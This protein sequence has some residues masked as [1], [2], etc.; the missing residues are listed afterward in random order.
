[1]GFFRGAGVYFQHFP[2]FVLRAQFLGVLVL[3]RGVFVEAEVAGRGVITVFEYH[4]ARN[5][6][7]FEFGSIWFGGGSVG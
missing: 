2:R 1:M 6:W 4:V 5:Y 3:V 7:V